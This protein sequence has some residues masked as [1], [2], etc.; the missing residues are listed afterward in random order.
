MLSIFVA[1]LFFKL[2]LWKPSRVEFPIDIHILNR[3]ISV[4]LF[5]VLWQ[6]F[7]LVLLQF[8]VSR[9]TDDK[10][11]IIY[12]S[13]NVET[14]GFLSSWI[15]TRVMLTCSEWILMWKLRRFRIVLLKKSWLTSVKF[16]A[17]QTSLLLFIFQ[18]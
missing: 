14:P 16:C 12:D 17:S 5:Y 11:T 18:G 10:N 15:L 7:A 6:T 8:C 1:I 9:I 3:P 2:K 4:Y 13:R